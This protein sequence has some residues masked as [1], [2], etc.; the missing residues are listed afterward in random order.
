MEFKRGLSD[1]DLRHI[2]EKERQIGIQF[3][4]TTSIRIIS[5]GRSSDFDDI[6]KAINFMLIRLKNHYHASI[7]VMCPQLIKEKICQPTTSSILQ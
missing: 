1:E 5:G 6:Q 2:E 7:H 4:A 3:R